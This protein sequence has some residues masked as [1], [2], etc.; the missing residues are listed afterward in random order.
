MSV[1]GIIVK[2]NVSV[3]L[4]VG[5]MMLSSCSLWPTAEAAT[6]FD[7]AD[8]GAKADG[9]SLDTVAVQAAIIGTSGH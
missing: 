4:V 6:V 8:Y 1:K 9:V 3:V 2:R 5:C 7:V